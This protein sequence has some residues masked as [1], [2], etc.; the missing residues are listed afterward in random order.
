MSKYIS[1][2][3]QLHQSEKHGEGK[4]INYYDNYFILSTH[5]GRKSKIKSNIN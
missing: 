4:L 2:V 3:P 5:N 1:I